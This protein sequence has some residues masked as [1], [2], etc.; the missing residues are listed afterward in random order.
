M[1]LNLEHSQYPLL[2]DQNPIDDIFILRCTDAKVKRSKDSYKWSFKDLS[3]FGWLANGMKVWFN[4]NI[5]MK[6][7]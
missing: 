5:V 1:T 2:L 3:G 6:S 4:D 7:P